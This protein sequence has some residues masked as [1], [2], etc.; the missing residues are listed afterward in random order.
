MSHTTLFIADAQHLFRDGLKLL[1][2]SKR[3]IRI[4]GEG[5]DREQLFT[6]LKKSKP[7]V[8]II[9]C[10]LPGYFMHRDIQHI[11]RYSPLSKI[12][13]I[14]SDNDKM[15]IFRVLEYGVNGFLTKECGKDQIIKAIYALAKGEKF[16]C[17]KVLDMLLTKK[18]PGGGRS[19]KPVTLSGR[20]TE[21]AKSIAAGKT[22]KDIAKEF[23]ISIH[24]VRTHR[25]N[26]MKK[27]GVKSVSELVLYA[28]ENG[29]VN[30]EN[31][32]AGA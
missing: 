1:L 2:K 5:G 30:P 13:V 27:L 29:M 31:F 26:I 25:K 22:T 7:D 12:L 23:Y 17:D 21:I 4:I 24:T 11:H 28:V 19:Y 32:N 8:V 3:D 9:D 15:N 6:A 20:E 16:F 10:N 18:I 14:S